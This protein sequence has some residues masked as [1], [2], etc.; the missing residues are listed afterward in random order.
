MESTI[1]HAISPIT[2][3]AMR[4]SKLE[5]RYVA[6]GAITT[7]PHD[8]PEAEMPKAKPRFWTNHL[9]TVEFTTTYTPPVPK[10]NNKP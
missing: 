3:N 9:E 2:I 6:N 7:A 5:I 4:Q 1:S 10:A 8:P